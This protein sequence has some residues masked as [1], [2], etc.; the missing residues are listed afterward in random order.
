M[1]RAKG[2]VCILGYAVT[3]EGAQRLLYK[4]S[5]ERMAGPLDVE[6]M[7]GCASG[8]IRCLAVNPNLVGVYRAPGPLLKVSDI[9]VPSDSKNVQHSGEN[10]MGERSVQSLLRKMFGSSQ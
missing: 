10:P 4:Y 6:L 3:Q 2:P 8:T 5:L 1:S 7:V 9:D